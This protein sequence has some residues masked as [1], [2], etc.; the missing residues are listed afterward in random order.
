MST[1]PQSYSYGAP[2]AFIAILIDGMTTRTITT[3]LS[4]RPEILL[5]QVTV[6]ISDIGTDTAC[7]AQFAGSKARPLLS[8]PPTS[9]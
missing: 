2:S 8:G 3:R 4:N 1:A 7:I 9:P 6:S 5:I